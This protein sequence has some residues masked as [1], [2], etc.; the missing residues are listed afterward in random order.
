MD[1][2]IPCPSSI[3]DIPLARWAGP[4]TANHHDSVPSEACLEKTPTNIPRWSFFCRRFFAF[5]KTCLYLIDIWKIRNAFSFSQNLTCLAFY[6]VSLQIFLQR[7]CFIWCSWKVL[8]FFFFFFVFLIKIVTKQ[9][10]S[11]SSYMN[12]MRSKFEVA[13]SI[14]V[15]LSPFWVAKFNEELCTSLTV[16]D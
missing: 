13:I 11:W 6:S 1:P 7:L 5:P 4:V 15:P 8:S 9:I 14:A 10:A 3:Q 16:F 12:L 2:E